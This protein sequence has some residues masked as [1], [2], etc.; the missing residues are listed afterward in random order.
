MKKITKFKFSK[1]KLNTVIALLCLLLFAICLNALLSTFSENVTSITW[2]GSVSTSLNG[3][4]TTA[5][6]Y[7]INNGADF[8]YFL[9]VSSNPDY[10]NKYYKLTKNINFNNLELGS[11]RTSTDPFSGHFDG[12]GY[13]IFNIKLDNYNTNN[14]S[15]EYGIFAYLNNANISNLN[16]H[17]ANIN[18]EDLE[19][20]SNIGI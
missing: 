19:T 5:D 14:G 12:N 15:F 3:T 7:L 17:D 9:S 11:L 4:G 1:V 8:A 2:D 13:T 18:I 6:P 10:F 16:I 20:S